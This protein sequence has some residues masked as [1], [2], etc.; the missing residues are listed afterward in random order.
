MSSLTTNVDHLL[1]V[2]IIQQIVFE[3]QRAWDLSPLRLTAS[4]DLNLFVERQGD[5]G[6]NHKRHFLLIDF[7]AMLALMHLEVNVGR[8]IRVLFELV[9]VDI[10]C[11]RP[12]LLPRFVFHLNMV[13]PR[14]L[15]KR[16]V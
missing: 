6:F 1:Q 11:E 3:L 2:P 16:I 15:G 12:C 14:L 7:I 5:I 13:L 9:E 10:A 4:R 8:V